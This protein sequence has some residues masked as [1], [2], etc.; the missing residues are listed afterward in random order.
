MLSGGFS[1]SAKVP[2]IESPSLIL[3]GRQDTILD[4]EFAQKFTDVLPD[5]ELKWIEECGHVPHL[6]QPEKTAEEIAAF[7]LSD[8]FVSE[9]I[10][11]VPLVVGDES[12]S[13][14]L[15]AGGLGAVGV[16]AAAI[17]GSM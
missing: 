6:E 9:D 8:K 3:W 7:L 12:T 13:Q 2:T 11:G 17:I 14:L 15:V 1:P 16:A 5:S 10:P 4:I